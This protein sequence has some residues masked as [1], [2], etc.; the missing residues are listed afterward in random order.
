MTSG[1]TQ[2][3]SEKGKQN[4]EKAQNKVQGNENQI[5]MVR[6]NTGS[7]N[8]Q[9]T[10]AFITLSVIVIKNFFKANRN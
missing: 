1:S 4:R 9:Y 7:R 6:Q 3:Q 8:T 2:N 10:C 5:E